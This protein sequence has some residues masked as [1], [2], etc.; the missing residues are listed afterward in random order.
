MLYL[1]QLLLPLPLR[2]PAMHLV[3]TQLHVVRLLVLFHLLEIL[4]V[5]TR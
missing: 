1:M 5:A 2:L 3:R 4:R